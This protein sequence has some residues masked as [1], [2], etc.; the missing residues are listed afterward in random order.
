MTHLK[1]I[2]S[3]SMAFASHE[4]L[5]STFLCSLTIVMKGT[6]NNMMKAG[7]SRRR[8]K[9]E[10]SDQKLAEAKRKKEIDDRLAELET[11]K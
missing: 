8:T 4:L 3:E 1:S 10:I 9:A 2:N 6:S 11:L 7:A 5:N